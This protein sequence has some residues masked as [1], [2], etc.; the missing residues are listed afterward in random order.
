MPLRANDTLS[1]SA[2]LGYRHRRLAVQYDGGHHLLDA[3]IC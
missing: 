1:P 2:D 3:Q